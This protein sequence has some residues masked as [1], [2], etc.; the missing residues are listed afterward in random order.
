MAK[1]LLM[2][3]GKLTD[4]EW[5]WLAKLAVWDPSVFPEYNIKP[6]VPPPRR[7]SFEKISRSEL[8]FL[9]LGQIWKLAQQS[10][11]RPPV[12]PPEES[13][14]AKLERL[15]NEGQNPSRLAKTKQKRSTTGR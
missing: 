7:G 15:V 5:K 4:D 13:V 1:N 12:L 10:H 6:C 3:N 9:D 11:T 2:L 8:L 14:F